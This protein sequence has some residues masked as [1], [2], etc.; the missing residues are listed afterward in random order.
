MRARL[1]VKQWLVGAEADVTAFAQDVSMDVTSRASEKVT[2]LEKKEKEEKEDERKKG[3]KR[4]A[5]L[6][7]FDNPLKAKEREERERKEKEIEEKKD[8]KKKARL[9]RKH[10]SVARTRVCVKPSP[11]SP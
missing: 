2:A 6:P 10:N 11:R 5:T 7:E 8:E 3:L 4:A 1:R 9:A